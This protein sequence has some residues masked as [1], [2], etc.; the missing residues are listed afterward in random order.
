LDSK[1][2]TQSSKPFSSFNSYI[3]RESITNY[4]NAKS[5]PATVRKMNLQEV[6]QAPFRIVTI[7]EASV[8]KTSLIT[9]LIESHFD[10][11]VQ[12]TI[13]ANFRT[14]RQQIDSEVIELEI[15]DTA[16][17]ERFRALSPI[18]YR[19]ADA[20]I[21]VFSMANTA[22]MEALIEIIN[23]FFEVAPNAL[24]VL[25]GNKCDIVESG[26]AVSRERA[27]DFGSEHRWQVF[28]TS[29]RTGVGV[30]ELFKELSVQLAT[31]K[32]DRQRVL[33]FRAED[34]GSQGCC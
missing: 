21:A 12:P 20:A 26:Q 4:Q 29:A 5:S 3:K 32:F 6:K 19:G 13:S 15:W 33:G 16:G 24:V 11:M 27:T 28:F 8:G 7:G 10:P 30:R 23:I 14:Y 9:Q 22:S 17:Q 18:Y 31:S 2:Q 25:V 34:N 1:P